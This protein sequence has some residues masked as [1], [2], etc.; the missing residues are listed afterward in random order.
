MGVDDA[1]PIASV[2]VS[3]DGV[4][5]GNASY[6]A[7]RTD[8]CNTYPGR[9]GCPNVGWS[10]GVNLNSIP[11]GNHTLTIIATAADGR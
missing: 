6:G 9:P 1:F 7:S 10:P 4:S 3:I 8:V 5:Y 2:G 11:A